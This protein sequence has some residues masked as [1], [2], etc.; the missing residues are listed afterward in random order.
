MATSYSCEQQSFIFRKQEEI[1]SNAKIFTVDSEP[2]QSLEEKKLEEITVT[3]SKKI[4]TAIKKERKPRR[5]GKRIV[6]N[7]AGRVTYEEILGSFGVKEGNEAQVGTMVSKSQTDVGNSSRKE[8]K[9]PSM[10]DYSRRCLPK[11][12][13]GLDRGTFLMEPVGMNL[14]FLETHVLIKICSMVGHFQ[15]YFL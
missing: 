2:G 6:W 1:G 9:A 12:F 14:C 8:K 3:E 5:I 11:E 15:L 10:W 7:G 13:V 4:G